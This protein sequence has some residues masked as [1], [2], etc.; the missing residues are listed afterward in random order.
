MWRN[1]DSA[2]VDLLKCVENKQ[3]FISMMI[4]EEIVKYLQTSNCQ[5]F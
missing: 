4:I 3:M 2:S 5:F 1:A